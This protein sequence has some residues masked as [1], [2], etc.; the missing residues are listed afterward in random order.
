M[1]QTAPE[2]TGQRIVI[3]DGVT[4][5]ICEPS[6]T[7]RVECTRCDHVVADLETRPWITVAIGHA[8]SHA[9]TCNGSQ[10]QADLP[11]EISFAEARRGQVIEVREGES[12]RRDRIRFITA[13]WIDGETL[14]HL[15]NVRN[16]PGEAGRHLWLIEDRPRLVKEDL[17]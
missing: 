13:N 15:W 11:R 17:R 9:Q 8:T 10:P 14:F 16:E 7:V 12:V 3:A 5:T 6:E 2:Y 4:A 1:I